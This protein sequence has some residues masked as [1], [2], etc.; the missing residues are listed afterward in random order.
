MFSELVKAADFYEV[1]GRQLSEIKRIGEERGLYN[2]PQLSSNW[3]KFSGFRFTEALGSVKFDGELNA[4][5]LGLFWVNIQ[6]EDALTAGGV[7]VDLTLTGTQKLEILGRD[8]ND[9]FISDSHVMIQYGKVNGT[10]IVS[11]LHS[12][13]PNVSVPLSNDYLGTYTSLK[14][15]KAFNA[16]G[17]AIRIKASA[18]PGL[19]T[20]NLRLV[21]ANGPEVTLPITFEVKP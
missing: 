7:L 12:T 6:N 1:G 18:T 11:A 13:D 21:P 16:T 4:G 17:I 19:Q 8:Y 14:N 3:A 2:A 9:G 10:S 20:A 15:R 5:D